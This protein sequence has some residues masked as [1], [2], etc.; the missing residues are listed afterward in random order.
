MVLIWTLQADDMLKLSKL[1]DYAVLVL[2]ALRAERAG[3]GSA[4]GLASSTGVPEPTT[5]KLLKLLAR[6]RLVESVRGPSGGY[7]LARE[8]ESI[9][10]A[11]IVEAIDGPIALVSCVGPGRG[12]CDLEPVCSTRQRWQG[13]NG[14]VRE[15]LAGV[16]LSE[17]ASP[18]VRAA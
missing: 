2:S 8:A 7:R 15:A 1:S 11:D 5:A 9:S 13:V 14:I 6:A 3:C 4:S 16:S 17:M 12:N 18:L 10:L